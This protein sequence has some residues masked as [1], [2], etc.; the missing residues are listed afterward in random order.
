MVDTSTTSTKPAKPGRRWFSPTLRVDIDQETIDDSVRRDSSHCMIAE[1]IRKL[2]PDAAN[3]SVDLGT[4]RWTDPRKRLRYTYLTPRIAQIALIDYDRG[5]APDPFHFTLR[6][7]A[8]VTR[9]GGKHAK[10]TPEQR[11]AALSR[12]DTERTAVRTSAA[13]VPN[14]LSLEQRAEVRRALD[15][16]NAPLGVAKAYPE[17][18]NG[19]V[20]TIVGGRPPPPGNLARMRRFGLRQLRQ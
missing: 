13:T 10:K 6:M 17:V 8:F 20:P 12:L 18:L 1:T 16:P 4:I 14:G 5:F 15:D 9:S 2:L 19:S 11:A 3:V 7:A